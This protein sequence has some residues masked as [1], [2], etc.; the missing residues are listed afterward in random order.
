MINEWIII[1]D[2]GYT[3]HI[4]TMRIKARTIDKAI[5][6]SGLVLSQIWCCVLANSKG[7]A[8]AAILQDMGTVVTIL[9]T[10]QGY[11]ST[12]NDQPGPKQAS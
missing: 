1:Y 11:E 4:F 5:I 2:N 7:S 12:D 10:M 9:D 6:K 8:A 3:P